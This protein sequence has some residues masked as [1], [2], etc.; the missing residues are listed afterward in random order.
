MEAIQLT[1]DNT[2]KVKDFLGRSFI[3]SDIRGTCIG[4]ENPLT[5]QTMYKGDYVVREAD[6]HC[7]VVS[8]V[9]FE[10]LYD[11]VGKE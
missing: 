3:G 9:I 11:L 7:Y 2:E 8:K 1:D 5:I 4:V 10:A 6:G